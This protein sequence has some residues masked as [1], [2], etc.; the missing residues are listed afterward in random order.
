MKK[1]KKEY[2]FIAILLVLFFILTMFVI[3]EKTSVF[4]EKIF[5]NII[6]LV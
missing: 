1:L 3:S 4:D 5:N 2:L 6:K